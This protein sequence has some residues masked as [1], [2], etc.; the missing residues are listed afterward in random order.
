MRSLRAQLSLS[1]HLSRDMLSK[2]APQVLCFYCL[3]VVEIFDDLV[4]IGLCADCL[5]MN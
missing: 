5:L 4:S 1:M 2:V 3:D